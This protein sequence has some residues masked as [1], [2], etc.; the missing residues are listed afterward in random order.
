MW[1]TQTLRWCTITGAL[2]LATVAVTYLHKEVAADPAGV[3]TRWWDGTKKT[4]VTYYA[5]GK[6]ESRTEYGDDGKTVIA[7]R[8]YDWQ[9]NLRQ[10]KIRLKNGNVEDSMYGFDGKKNILRQYTLWLGDESN[11]LVTQM[12][13]DNGQLRLEVVKTD[14][15]LVAKHSRQWDENG[16]LLAESQILP[17]AAQ[18]TD[19][20]EEGKLVLRQTLYGTGDLVTQSFRADGTMSNEEK[21][22]KLTDSS[23]STYFDAKGVPVFGSEQWRDGTEVLNLYKNGV[24]AIKHTAYK[25][26]S[27]N[28]V[29]ELSADG[30][31]TRKLVFDNNGNPARV[32]LYRGDGTL[33]REKQLSGKGN[34]TTVTKQLDYDE[35]GTKVT[36]TSDTGEPERFERDVL[37]TGGAFNNLRRGSK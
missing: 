25:P 10:E 4:Q 17:N 16:V 35:T 19:Q 24:L 22:I 26:G 8:K 23:E 33:A 30:K 21:M 15:G 3:E 29:E 7:F 28:Y 37:D 14:D 20:Y 11:F 9:G 18:Q 1:L 6:V 12:Y 5:D 32:Y 36:A 34:T 27:P 13:W 31:V 2:M